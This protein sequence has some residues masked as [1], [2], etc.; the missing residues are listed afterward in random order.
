MLIFVK[1]CTD[2]WAFFEPFF[3]KIVD[4]SIKFNLVHISFDFIQIKSDDF[5][6][7]NR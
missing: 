7:K 2:F 5:L 1:F 3:E 4:Y 6:S